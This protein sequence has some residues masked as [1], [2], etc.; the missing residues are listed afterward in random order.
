MFMIQKLLFCVCLV[1]V[2]T[3]ARSQVYVDGI[4]INADTS[5]HY[6]ELV[7]TTSSWGARTRSIGIYIRSIDIGTKRSGTSFMDESG[8]KIDLYTPVDVISYMKR[9]GWQMLRRDMIFESS[10][11]SGGTA[12]AFALFERTN[13]APAH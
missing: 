3:V 4:N 10:A 1:M 11:G 13:T 9:N 12:L 8:K 2:I 5:V 7:Y 6:I